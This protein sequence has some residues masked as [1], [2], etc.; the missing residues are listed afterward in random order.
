M[1]N[2]LTF[3][4]TCSKG[5]EDLLVT[6]LNDLGI[7]TAKQ[8]YS[9]VS[10]TGSLEQAYKSCLWSRLASR[11]FLK[12]TTF[13]A[14]DDEQLYNGVQTINWPQHID[15]DGTLAVNCT[16]NRSE[17]TNSHYASLR[18]KDAV[19]DQFNELYE[20][21]PS[22]DR[23]QPD[24]R[25]NVHIDHDQVDVSI[26]LSGEPL[27]KRGY[28]LAS[29]QAPLKENLAAAILIRS[30][31]S[32]GKDDQTLDL[33]DPMCG[34]ATFL[35]EAA[36]MSL[37]I[38]PGLKRK[39]FGFLNWKGHD[40][41]SWKKLLDEAKKSVKSISEINNTF[42]GYD[43][44]KYS[45][46]P[47]RQNIH[48]AGLQDL[49]TLEHKDLSESCAHMAEHA[50]SI[51]PGMV[52]V[53]PPYGERLGEKQELAHLYAEMG[54]CWRDNFPDWKIALFTANDELIK[55]VGLRAHRTNSFFNGAIKCKLLQYQIRPA[56]SE[57][58]KREKVEKYT[59]QRSSILNR[60]KKNF[61]HIGRWARKNKVQAYRLYSADLP[62]YSAAIDIYGDWVHVQEY[63]AP[64]SIDINKARQR[65]EI[66]VDVIPEVLNIDKSRIV[67]KTRR[68]QKGL[69]QYEKQANAH[70][71]FIV[72][73]N[74]FKFH[75]NLNDY[76]DTGLF[77]DHRDTRKYV[78]DKIV[79]SPSAG[80][81]LNLF[82]YTS[83]FSVYAAAA[84]ADTTS[85]DMSNTYIKWS[86]RNFSSNDLLSDKHHFIKADCMQ[87]LVIA[88]RN[89]EKFKWIFID[90]PTFS[91]SKSMEDLFDVQKDHES[92]IE[93][94]M[95]L[96]DV[97]GEIIFSNNFKKFK[98]DKKLQ[99]KYCVENI[100]ASTIPEDFKRNPK[101]H[102]CF[103]IKP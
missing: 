8:E 96:L 6:E 15:M 43:A 26:D 79:K 34:S 72:E 52:V 38:A 67:V 91:N 59:E 56:L 19:V 12:L 36:M 45:I 95:G 23:E 73:E 31:W 77:L 55:H 92:L 74:G 97:G 87:W 10:F 35:I 98:L 53:N 93:L 33:L 57:E 58:K 84:G 94:A 28:R 7:D 40:A 75:V 60:L 27:H 86:E 21:R 51:R 81:F 48:S 14:L 101:I 99:E 54:A 39:F 69:S 64:S 37:N 2:N 76:L 82:S 65:F 85:V 66:L 47:A 103:I 29:V 80:K 1:K 42:T 44:N 32:S 88:N 90:P 5:F 11:V 83:A 9:G 46:A 102:H 61:K 68:Q 62:E 24:V 16:I 70:H 4:A 17:I 50:G 49:I 3:F 71:E 30:G 89:N 25:I 22:V 41:D 100:T 18:T 78:Y 63:Q 13:E 20:T